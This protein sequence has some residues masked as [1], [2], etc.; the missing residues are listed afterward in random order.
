VVGVTGILLIVFVVAHLLGNLQI[1]LGQKALNDYA[2]LLKSIP[3]PLW[4]ARIGLLAA[5]VIHLT[6]ALRLKWENA[7]A[8]PELYAAENTAE[9]SV[10]SRIMALTGSI[11]LFYVIGHVLHFT[12]GVFLPELHQL[13]DSQGRQDVFLMMVRSFQIPAVSIAY[14]ISMCFLWSHLSHGISSVF[15]TLGF[16]TSRNRAIVDALGPGLSGLI[17]L[18]YISIPLAV[19]VGLVK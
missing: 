8:R 2:A 12:L 3:L 9:A 1:F 16:R 18:G 10:S 17:L 7:R 13:H 11:V 4:I 5:F 15:Q 6:V 19:L 14:I